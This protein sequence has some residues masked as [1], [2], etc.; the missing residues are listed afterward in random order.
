MRNWKEWAALVF[1]AVLWFVILWCVAGSF[2]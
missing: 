1:A 2:Y